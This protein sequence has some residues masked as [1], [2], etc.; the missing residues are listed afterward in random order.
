VSAFDLKPLLAEISPDAPSGESDP[1]TESKIANLEIKLTEK[2]ERLV[3]EDDQ[4]E[5]GPDWPKIRD[6]AIELLTHTHDL[7]VAMFFIRAMLH[8]AELKGLKTGLELLCGLIEQYWESLYPRLDPDDDNDPT[9]RIS[10]LWSLVEGPDII[11]PL[12]K[13]TL[14]DARGIGQFSLRDIHI[15][16]GKIKLIKAE[17]SVP[18]M[19]LIDGAFKESDLEELKATRTVIDES[20]Q[21]VEALSNLLNEKINKPTEQKEEGSP[22]VKKHDIPEFEELKA[23]LG[24][25]KA[26]VAKQLEIR[27]A[28]DAPKAGE[29]PD[30]G[31][32][33]N[34]QVAEKSAQGS[35]SMDTINT[36][37]DVVRALDKICNY[38][39]NNEPGSPVPLLLKR[40]RQLVE[41]NFF[42]IMQDL[43]LDSATQIKTLF[44]GAVDDTS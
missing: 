37:Q 32:A 5:I 17:S 31:V 36:R 12:A 9:E 7:R 34:K 40:A 19:E 35:G 21:Y 28:S 38:Y 42:E 20:L 16:S 4:E 26:V 44:S 10:L 1:G 8:T 33:G 43:E 23:T 3:G 11:G 30:A 27:G 22:E 25:M 15:A 24:D 13:A 18:S 41:K 39:Q 29:T 6:E 14:V 2:R